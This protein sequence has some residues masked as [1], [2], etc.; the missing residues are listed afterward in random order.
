MSDSVMGRTRRHWRLPAEAAVA[1]AVS[2]IV[3]LSMIAAPAA[4]P[5][6]LALLS[7]GVVPADP[8]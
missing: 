8:G 2:R 6:A 5:P 3:A 7:S 1:G 4:G